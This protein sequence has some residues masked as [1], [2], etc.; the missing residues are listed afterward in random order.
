MRRH[1]VTI[2]PRP[3]E[4]NQPKFSWTP[5]AGPEPEK[6]TLLSPGVFRLYARQPDA[7][8]PSHVT[9]GYEV[10][11]RAGTIHGRLR[12]DGWIDLEPTTGRTVGSQW[13]FAA[14]AP[15]SSTAPAGA[16]DKVSPAR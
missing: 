13:L 5:P 6:I 11:G 12:P 3:H 15:S 7:N 2:H 14:E 8:D 1:W 10:D 9:V 4:P 16:S